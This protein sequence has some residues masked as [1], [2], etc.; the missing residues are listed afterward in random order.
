MNAEHLIRHLNAFLAI[1]RYADRSNNG[2]QVQCPPEVTRVA[3][4]VDACLASFERAV[5]WKAQ[6]LIVHHGL[7]WSEPLLLTGAHFERVRTLICGE[8]G[9]YA[10][11]IPLD[12]H[13]EVGNNAQLARMA[14]LTNLTPWGMHK[15]TPIGYIGDLPEPLPVAQLAE[16]LAKHIGAPNRIQAAPEAIARRVAVCSGFGITLLEEALAAGADTLITGETSHM[17]FHPAAERRLSVIFGGH[18]N[19]ETVGLKALAEHLEAQFGL[20]THFIDLPTGL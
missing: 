2:L 17:W 12:A 16:R 3:F 18:Y 14:G 9:L 5:A 6:L 4:A 19:T 7:F 13:P 1:D 11:H 8:C 20:T 10:A 15:G